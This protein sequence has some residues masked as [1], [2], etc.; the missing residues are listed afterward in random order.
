[1]SGGHR[2]AVDADTLSH[3]GIANIPGPSGTGLIV[4][5]AVN[6]GVAGTELR[7]AV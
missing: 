3:D 5:A 2:H 6:I 1:M 4:T 7:V